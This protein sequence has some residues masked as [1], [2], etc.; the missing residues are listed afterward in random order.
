MTTPPLLLLIAI[1]L[2]I[3]WR[4]R[5]I[6]LGGW[7][8]PAAVLCRLLALAALG[9]ALL[10]A[11]ASRLQ[12]VPRHVMYVVDGSA[13]IDEA[14]RRWF[15]RRIASL[16]SRRPAQV[17]R[18]LIAFGGD[19]RLVMPFDREPLTDPEALQQQLARAPIERG[20]TNLEA[21]LLSAAAWLPASREPSAARAG[22]TGRVGVVLLSDG[23]ET[24][25]NV[26]GVLSSVRRLG[27]EVFPEPPPAAGAVKTL[28]QHL[29]VP[30]VVRQGAPIPHQLVVFSGSPQPTQGRVT[31]ALHG[32]VITRQR[33]VVRPGWQVFTVTVPAIGRGT[34]AFE[35]TWELPSERILEP[36]RAYTEVEG[37]PRLL[38]V[39]ERATHP[40]LLAQA[41]KRREIDVMINRLSDLPSDESA[42]REYD[43]VLLFGVPKSALSPEQA[44]ALRRYVEAFGAGLVTV[45]LGGNLADELN[46]PAPIDGLLPVRFEPKGLQES[47]RRVCVILLIDRSA[48]MLGPRIAATKRAAVE[49]VKQ[50][51]PEDLVG[52]LAFDTQPYVVAEVQPAGQIGSWL[53]DTL[54]KLKSSG[55]TDVF[56]AL[57]AAADRL[58]LTGASVKHI[59]LL[60][61]GNTP[62]QESGYRALIGSF[63]QDH[64]S[65][66]TIGVGAAF[67]NTDYLRWLAQSTGGTFYPLRSLDELPK[68]VARDAERAVGKLPFAE[69]LFRPRKD[70]STD[71]FAGLDDWPSLRG[72]LTATA[73][74]GARTDLT[75][76]GG[77][78][79]DPLLARWAVGRGRVVS[80][81][82]DADVRW[83]P[84]WVRWDGFEGVWA[85]VVRWAMRPRLT[86]ELFVSV[87]ASRQ[88]P[89]LILEGALQDPR[90]MLI[91]AEQPE[92]TVP[93]S[94][95]QTGPWRWQASLEQVASG[96]YQLALETSAADRDAAGS[97]DAPMEPR[98]A[99]SR[100]SPD[101]DGTSRGNLFAKRWVQV[102]T[103]PARREAPGQLPHD[104]LLRQIAR[105]TSGAYDLADRA[106][107]PPATTVT[108]TAPL[109]GLWLPLAILALLLDIALRGPTM[110]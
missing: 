25:G 80:F 20:Q 70:P 66:S 62:F 87:D 84:E 40:P 46:T 50:L 90:G 100:A 24:V 26:A 65:V 104:E 72:Y 3:L 44:E 92:T 17:P 41:L 99:E 83:A 81:T 77:A 57:G 39:T 1:V 8:K 82:S 63:Q 35:D 93:L 110:L 64:V 75:V 10:G 43:A 21:A 5:R 105:A 11:S 103:P 109:V 47:K 6:P 42:L 68:L 52:V 27:L 74:P 51:A 36:R 97:S 28:W 67:I 91:A 22:S 96:W 61:D 4:S 94:F 49:L 58:E 76:S 37:P 108:V 73:R 56:P 95:V 34:M 106:F 19:A 29:A 98:G 38:L 69:G 59:I 13:S 16:E 101:A 18:A 55:G 88:I 102:G 45:G 32:V 30:P 78:G 89:R 31:I 23:R 12:D 48:S 33:V 14:Q 79:D 2:L 7:R 60:S 71:W 85:Q 54:V 9:A 53:V 86:E 15:A 107:V